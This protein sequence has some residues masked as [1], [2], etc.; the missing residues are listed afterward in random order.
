MISIQTDI[1]VIGAGPHALAMIARLSEE[2]PE[3][4][5]T[6][7]E[8][9]RLLRVRSASNQ[10]KHKGERL[11]KMCLCQGRKV[12]V[13]DPN[14]DWMRNW[15][16]NF[17]TL[18]ISHLRSPIFFHLDPFD[19]QG[20]REFAERNDR[21]SELTNIES[22]YQSK[23]V[24]IRM[25][26]RFKNH[27]VFN[28]RDRDRFVLPSS[29]LF[30]DYCHEMI[31]RYKMDGLV[32]QAS[33]VDI[34]PVKVPGSLSHI[35][36]VHLSN[37]EVVI[38]N[39]VIS[40]IGPGTNRRTPE[41]VEGVG[42]TH[43]L[44]SL[45]HA[46]DMDPSKISRK[47]ASTDQLLIVGGGLTAGHLAIIAASKGYKKIIMISRSHFR[48]QQFDVEI[49]WMGRYGKVSMAEFWGETNEK[50]RLKILRQARKGGSIT[51]Q[52]MQKLNQLMKDGVLEMI[53]TTQVNQAIWCSSSNNWKVELTN[54]TNISASAIWLST[55][56]CQNSEIN[57]N[58][59]IAFKKVIDQ[60]N[61]KL[62]EGLPVVTEDLRLAAGENIFIMGAFA[63]LQLGPNALNLIGARS[64]S[65]RIASAI[66]CE[67]IYS[68]TYKQDAVE[69]LVTNC[70]GYYDILAGA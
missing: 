22:I 43:P 38:A 29:A 52:V 10:K 66:G 31:S 59:E 12:M 27:N 11:K 7:D 9:F 36:R 67:V 68:D 4:L 48:T 50:E 63:A 57:L 32:K 56:R 53:P 37:G 26:K 25:N 34:E 58:R 6:D 15:K 65:E 2:H 62:I 35:Y 45:V 1:L 46:Y 5:L 41:W 55:G 54:D 60:L 21:I 23:N 24:A 40:A 16:K 47:A 49:S 70:G 69:A 51:P 17:S 33:V 18:Q 42:N 39:K 14:G 20:L 30:L 28:E 61:V 19:S 13:I 3:S 8:H 44:D 64:G